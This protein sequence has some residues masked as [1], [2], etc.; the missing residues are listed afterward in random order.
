MTMF[1][2]TIRWLGG[3]NKPQQMGAQSEQTAKSN[4]KQL[5]SLHLVPLLPNYQIAL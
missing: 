3:S 2:Y 1:V 5:P 4:R